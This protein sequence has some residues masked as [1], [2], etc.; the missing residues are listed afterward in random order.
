MYHC[1]RFRRKTIPRNRKN[2]GKKSVAPS[3]PKVETYKLS[4]VF[5]PLN[6]TTTREGIY[7]VKKVDFTPSEFRQTGTTLT[8]ILKR[9]IFDFFKHSHGGGRTGGGGTSDESL[10]RAKS[11]FRKSGSPKLR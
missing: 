11:K 5:V 4:P 1:E 2:H 7:E 3:V 9:P 8:P 6:G 10:S